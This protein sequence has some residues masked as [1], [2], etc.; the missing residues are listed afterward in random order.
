MKN[1]FYKDIVRL[2]YVLISIVSCFYNGGYVL[3]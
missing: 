2:V 1:F 3:K